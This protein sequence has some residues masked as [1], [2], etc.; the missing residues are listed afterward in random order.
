MIYVGSPYSDLD[1]L[2][3][4]D[5]A[6]AVARFVARYIKEGHILY[7]PIASW[8]HIAEQFTLPTDCQFWKQLN[9]GILRFASEMWVLELDGWRKSVGLAGEM[10]TARDLYIPIVHFDGQTFERV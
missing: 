6:F 5:R 9:F 3:R 8:H 4:A 2:V 10:D 7:S 1:H